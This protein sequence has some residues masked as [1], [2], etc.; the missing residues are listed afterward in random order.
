M[1][2]TF[3][4]SFRL[5]NTYRTNSILYAIKEI[6]FLGKLLKGS[7]YHNKGIKIIAQIIS[8]LWEL[9]AT[10][11]G[12]FIYVLILAFMILAYPT[13]PVDTFLHLFIFSTLI[14]AILNTYMFNPTKDKYYAIVLMNMNAKEFAVSNYIYTM[15]QFIIG[16]MPFTIYFGMGLKIPLW[17]CITMPFFVVAVKMSVILYSL[18]VFKRKG[19]IR[20]ENTPT[21]F[22]WI[23][24]GI[25]LIL[26]FGLPYINIIMSQSF[27]IFLFMIGFIIGI[28]SFI[29]II[30]FKE[31]K[32]MYQQLLTNQNVYV[33]QNV[34]STAQVRETMT[35]KIEYNGDLTSDKTGFAYFHELFVKRHSKLL[36]K[37]V[38]KQVYFIGIVFLIVFLF[39]ITNDSMK[40][41]VNAF[42]MT[43]LPYFVFLMY[44][45]NRG[46]TITQAMFINC[47][48]S[49]LTYRIYRTPKVILGVFKERLKTLVKI[50][51]IPAMA[52]ALGLVILLYFTG[53]K[54]LINYIIVFVAINSMS[55]FFSIH[56]LVMYYLLQPYN[57][58]TEIK[59]GTYT[60]VQGFTYFICY[61]MIS[62]KMSTDI[63]GIITIIFSILY[64]IIALVSVYKFAPKTFK[65]RA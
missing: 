64:S 31:Y 42:I 54:S 12:K 2:K 50:N 1:I 36:M 63:F 51:L 8:I 35:K 52:I 62:I 45:L 32:R 61:Y 37:A 5:K 16:L 6:P 3:I 7:L 56:Y 24:L 41:T 28:Y 57:I 21:K 39:V 11:F 53:E 23:L 55:I 38:K 60:L 59:N 13:N 65:I 40:Q 44:L 47:D 4:T 14:G 26:G 9:I 30:R 29:V 15:L 10:F 49:M 58:N 18:Q 34:T 33:V 22:T 25:F 48:H 46:S 19:I 27:S 20:S 43:Y 17:I